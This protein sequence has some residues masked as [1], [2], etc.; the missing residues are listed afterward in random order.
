MI[1]AEMKTKISKSSLWQQKGLQNI[2]IDKD[3]KNVKKSKRP[4]RSLIFIQEKMIMGSATISR[5]Y[6][7]KKPKGKK[8]IAGKVKTVS[9]KLIKKSKKALKSAKKLCL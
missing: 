6:Y 4:L 1:G 5:V 2:P 8:V 7:T 3:N 9:L